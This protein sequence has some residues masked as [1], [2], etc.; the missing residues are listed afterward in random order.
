MYFESHVTFHLL[1]D[2]SMQTC[3]I[4]TNNLNVTFFFVTWNQ[5]SADTQTENFV[6]EVKVYWCI[7]EN[8]HIFL[9]YSLPVKTASE[10]NP[11]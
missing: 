8:D 6:L 4:I 3:F 1:E 7:P 9:L 2:H 10:K 5:L 11:F